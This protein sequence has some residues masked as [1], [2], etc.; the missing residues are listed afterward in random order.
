MS[1]IEELARELRADLS[2][3]TGDEIGE[4]LTRITASLLKFGE[5]VREKAAGIDTCTHT[6]DPEC[7]GERFGIC[8]KCIRALNVGEI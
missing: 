1:Q 5:A 8:A 6:R 7:P 2:S 4:A 3:L